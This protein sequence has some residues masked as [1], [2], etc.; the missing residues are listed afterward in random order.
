MMFVFFDLILI[1]D[2]KQLSISMKKKIS[3]L[4]RF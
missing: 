1:F 2:Y 3:N 4:Y